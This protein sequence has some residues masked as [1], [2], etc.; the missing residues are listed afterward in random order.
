MSFKKRRC[1][2][3]TRKST[4]EGLDQ[5]FNSLDAQY[6]ACAA[7]ILSQAGEG[8]TCVK[9][10]YDDGGF[11]G[12]NM[13]RPGLK[14][15]MADIEAGRIDI[16]V[17]YKV[18]RLTRALSDFARIVDALDKH[19]ASFVS[20]TQAFNTTTSMGRL[21]L[22]V[23][24][25]FA[26]FEREV[27]GERIRDKIAA[28]KAKGMWM[29]GNPPLGY[30]V[31]ERALHINELEAATVRA[32]FR[33]Y[34][35]LPGTVSLRDELE[36][37]GVR[38]KAWVSGPGKQK[39]G[40]VFS[41]GGLNYLLRNR[42]YVGEV[43][44]RGKAY[45]GQHNAIVPREL[46]DAVQQKLDARRPDLPDIESKGRR[47]SLLGKVFDDLGNAMTSA[48]GNKR[49]KRYFYYVSTAINT[50]KP[51]GSVSRVS[52]PKLEAALLDCVTP[53]LKPDWC[54]DDAPMRRVTQALLRVVLHTKH[55]AITLAPEAVDPARAALPDVRADDDRVCFQAPLT[56]KPTRRACTLVAGA[57]Q[58]PPPKIDRAL[59]RAIVLA[60]GW[61]QELG[62]ADAPSLRAIAQREDVCPHYA[63]QILPLAFLA[64]DLVEAVLD[65]RQ[66]QALS[67][68]GLIAQPLPPLW[69]EQRALFTKFG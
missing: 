51:R 3:Y 14:A 13:D 62:R 39:G 22:N 18:D 60:R 50:G 38:S 48:H 28:S 36:R 26:Q 31:R 4:D 67:L 32:I 66:P 53:M 24:L 27:T 44:H 15:L 16:V 6:E 33:R 64:P 30:D 37:T 5:S 12:G 20:V 56:F 57:D 45:R 9:Q 59:V 41:R 17:V 52:A 65:G 7:Y 43:V 54:S 61:A 47:A 21:T 25:S 2:I 46:F 29:G 35:E 34:L 8:W 68:A 63:R 40:A 49:G 42:L 23:L 69:A 55:M 58:T 11:S 19:G 10:R 1:A